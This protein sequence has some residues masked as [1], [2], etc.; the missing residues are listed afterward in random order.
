MSR[1]LRGARRLGQR[2]A[3]LSALLA[4]VREAEAA[5]LGLAGPDWWLSTVV[6]VQRRRARM[7]L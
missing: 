1:R 5:D 3:G 4:V 7:G 6:A 2:A